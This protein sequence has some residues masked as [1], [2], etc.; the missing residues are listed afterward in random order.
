MGDQLLPRWL[1]KAKHRPLEAKTGRWMSEKEWSANATDEYLSNLLG[2][3]KM[4]KWLYTADTW[5]APPWPESQSSMTSVDRKTSQ[6]SWDGAPRGTA[7]LSGI[8]F[9]RRQDQSGPGNTLTRSTEERGVFSKT[10]A[11]I[12]GLCSTQTWGWKGSPVCCHWGSFLEGRQPF[13][14]CL[15][16]SG[17][18]KTW[19]SSPQKD[20][21]F[22]IS[23]T[24][25]GWAPTV[26]ITIL[27]PPHDF[28]KGWERSVAVERKEKWII[29]GYC[30]WLTD[31]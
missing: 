12:E 22:N 10:V 25:R 24:G 14:L 8:C 1:T 16:S 6:A 27:L 11:W 5:Q 31:L 13:Y 26:N 29:S 23:G 9:P 7:I 15:P 2:K 30:S 28:L 18:T 17:H 3:H 19:K 21:E 4:G 20:A